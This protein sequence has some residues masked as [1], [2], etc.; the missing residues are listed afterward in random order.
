MRTIDEEIL[1]EVNYKKEYTDSFI[2]WIVNDE[3]FIKRLKY[4]VS[5]ESSLPDRMIVKYVTREGVS[6]LKNLHLKMK[7]WTGFFYTEI[8]NAIGGI[9]WKVVISA[10]RDKI[11]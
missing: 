9:D 10:V 3:D 1:R 2:E 5:H 8:E 6:Y 7:G 4:W 11:A